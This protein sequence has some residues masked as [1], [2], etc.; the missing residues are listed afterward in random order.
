[1]DTAPHDLPN[2][3]RTAAVRFAERE[4]IVDG[5]TRM[6]YTELLE[7]VR[8]T[9]RAFMALGLAPGDRVGIWA[10]NCWQW[11]VAALAISYAGGTLVP[12]NTRYTGH[13]TVDIVARTHAK[14][15]VMAD[16]FLGRDQCGELAGAARTAES[17]AG[18]V[19]DGLPDLRTVVRLR[20]GDAAV[21][22]GNPRIIEWNRLDTVAARIPPAAAEARADAVGP[23]D[24]ADVLFTSGTTGRS[25][26]ARSS[27]RQVVSVAEAWSQCGRLSRD[28]RYLIVNP[29]FHSFG[30][31]AGFVACLLTGAT[32][33]PQAVFDVETTLRLI[34]DEAITVLPGAPTIYQSLLESPR[35]DA[36][37][38]GSLRLAVTGAA[39]VP[40]RLVER[41]QSELNFDTVLTAYGLTEAV[42]ATMCSPSDGDDV[43]AH[44]CGRAVGNLKVHIAAPDS[45]DAL[46]AGEQGEILLEG[47]N[48]MVGYLD[49]PAA[50][51]AA[52]DADGRLHT[53]DIGR[54]DEN[55][56]L[57]ITDRLKDV[58][59]VGGFN[60][61]P[62]EVEQT[63][64][65]LDG[66]VESAVVGVRD[67]RL[68]EVGKAFV[69][70][71]A[72]T[73]LDERQV[74]AYARQRMANFKVPRLIEFV[75]SLPRNPAG[76]VLK[77]ALR[78]DG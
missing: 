17:S 39:T 16:G 30:Y 59:I 6:T 49:D 5:E 77:S 13:E 67:P 55:G 29:Y 47:D 3:V 7:R 26:G 10:P 50:T 34:G 32:A 19:V 48:V 64:A 4:A 56:Y 45:G 65:H 69:V 61:Y 28:D 46:P 53:G 1:M 70:R 51:A 14:L 52:I 42:V 27:H 31:K 62:A 37:D 73:A 18:P 11:E 24:I 41:M 38:T 60:V 58:F 72:G 76:K 21:D 22:T 40:V 44:T 25:K 57:T 63:L 12:I 8:S 66:V 33:L 9:A 68:G 75:D 15:L 20:Y 74:T 2:A 54:L 71:R 43:V 78:S 36:F 23:D 35:R